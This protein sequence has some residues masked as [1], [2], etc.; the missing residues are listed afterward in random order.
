MVI[1]ILLK[2]N[3]FLKVDRK[4]GLLVTLINTCFV[5]VANF[6]IFLIIWMI[7]MSVLYSVLGIGTSSTGYASLTDRSFM[8]Y[9]LQVW[10]NSIGNISSPNFVDSNPSDSRIFFVY[11][12]WFMN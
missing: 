12:L 11:L 6:A 8:N 3:V 7:G 4:F 2:I 10:S 5:D 1:S 9:F